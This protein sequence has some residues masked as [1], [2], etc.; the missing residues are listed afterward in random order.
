MN[1]RNG[2][3]NSGLLASTLAVTAFLAGFGLFV[4]FD[5]SVFRPEE[6]PADYVYDI[7]SLALIEP[8][9]ILYQPTAE[10]IRF[11]LNFAVALDVD[12]QKTIYVAGDEKILV[13]GPL[14]DEVREIEL[15]AEP[16]CLKVA[17]GHIYVGLTDHI[18]VIRPDGAIQQWQV[19][20]EEAW[21]TAIA[22]AGQDV[23]A[24][25]ARNKVIWHFDGQGKLIKSIGQKD[26]DRSIP[27][28]VVPSP[29]FDIA[30]APDGLLR[31]VNPGRH[32][33]EAYT[34]DGDLEWSWGVAGM[35]LE[36]FSGCCNPVAI[37][38]LPAGGFITAEKGLVRVKE[39]DDRGNYIGVVAGPDQL[40][41]PDRLQAADTPEPGPAHQIDVAVD[42]DNKVYVLDC[43]RGIVHFFEKKTP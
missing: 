3:V 9:Q 27:G 42:A 32:L 14:E 22:V 31:A 41:W 26:A 24:A 35:G 8:D 10:P 18:E 29:N 30:I 33:I 25:D 20:Q 2:K 6:L 12:D 23:F 5:K 4:A 38:I 7:D 28:F 16:S 11:D 39:Y 40:A 19:P 15:E 34:F 13:A 36:G 21:L 17:D 1:H 43:V 37:A